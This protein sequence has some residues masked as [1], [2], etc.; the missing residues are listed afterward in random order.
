MERNFGEF[1]KQ[2]RQ[3]KNL[4]QKELANLLFV[5]ESAVS[6][7]EKNVAHPDITLLPRLSEILGVTEHELITAS[8]DNQAKQEKLQARKWR[9]FSMSWSLF[10]YISYAVAII[11]CFICNLAINKTLSWFWIVLSAL[12]LAFTFTNLPKLIKKHKLIF[13]PF[14]MYLALV[15]LLGVCCIY[16]GGNWFFIPTIAVFLGLMMV[17]APIYISKYDCFAKIR[18][19]N[20]FVS[21]ATCFVIL[22]I[23]LI[24]IDLFSVSNGA[25]N[26]W[27]LPYALPIVVVGYLVVTAL[28]CVRFLKVNR[29]LKTSIILALSDIFVYLIPL[30]I[31]ADNT[32]IQS[33]LDDINIFKADFSNWVGE[34][35]ERNVHCIIA[36]VILALAFIFFAV[37][38]F[39]HLKKRNKEVSK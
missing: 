7:W 10:F 19:Y 29:F 22:N 11:P 16:T 32:S 34:I 2:K 31:K 38:L 9:A 39:V 18:K 20:D 30:F 15:L 23:M 28:M 36:L 13:V 37:G 14:S 6:K 5:S 25:E 1:L 4:T 17:F 35:I 12:I 21:V 27:Y 24:A 26:H 3:E 33:A 8:V